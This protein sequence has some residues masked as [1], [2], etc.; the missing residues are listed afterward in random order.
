MYGH[1]LTLEEKVLEFNTMLNALLD[2]ADSDTRACEM[3]TS[4]ILTEETMRWYKA[5]R[6]A[7]R[8]AR[9]TLHGF[10]PYIESGRL[11]S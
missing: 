8:T 2:S 6:F 3:C 5:K 1:E 7:Y 11:D 4:G 10:F 9:E